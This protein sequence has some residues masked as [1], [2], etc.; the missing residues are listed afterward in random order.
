MARELSE[1]ARIAAEAMK[2]VKVIKKPVTNADFISTSLTTL[3]LAC[4]NRVYGG[5][6]KG[7]IVRLIG[8]TQTC[9]T[10]IAGSILAEAANNA[11]FA[12]YV[13]YHNHIERGLRMGIG[14]FWGQRAASRVKPLGYS[15]TGEPV[16]SRDL[17]DW[18]KSL[19]TRLDR[20]EKFI[21]I[22][23][24][25]DALVHED[26]ETKM[27]DGKAKVHSQEMRK[28]IDKLQATGSILVL[29]Q[30]AK[31]NL[32]NTW[33]ELVTTGGASPQLYSSLDIWLSKRG[34][35]KKSFRG[36]DY[37]VGNWYEAHVI[38]NRLSGQDRRVTFP[39]YTAYGI[40]DLEA[41][42][43]FLCDSN[44]WKKA[45]KNAG[46]PMAPTDD[47]SE[48]EYLA[49]SASAIATDAEA[50]EDRKSR[51]GMFDFSE[52]NFIGKQSELVLRIDKDAEAK[53]QLRE[54]T[55]KVWR[56]ILNAITP[57]REPR[58]S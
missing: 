40:D 3:N 10:V 29:I 55:A 9:K 31:T 14:K 49:A 57:Q 15:K 22:T 51:A 33:A 38:K 48:D 37:H 46:L 43:W 18:Y 32:G 20:R 5:L 21:E 6:E 2:M 8:K 58:Y 25:L 54:L 42:V 7:T 45:K 52:F 47:G 28:L 19:H 12:D 56:E 50:K 24:S 16:Y 4:A 35:L 44:H 11:G 53:K 41:C 36:C 17:L 13:L 26:G 34:P 23:D 30:H 1:S 39:L 27:G